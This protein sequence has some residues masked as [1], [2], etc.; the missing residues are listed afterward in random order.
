[1]YGQGTSSVSI[2]GRLSTFWSVHIRGSTMDVKKSV[3]SNF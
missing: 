2:V 3:K 1:M